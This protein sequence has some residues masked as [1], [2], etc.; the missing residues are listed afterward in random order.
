[1]NGSIQMRLKKSGIDAQGRRRKNV[2]V[3]D[4]YYR[5]KDPKTG[6]NKQKCRRGFPT[7]RD[8]EEYLAKLQVQILNGEYHEESNLTLGEYLHQW[9]ESYPSESGL[10]PN[11]EYS[12]KLHVTKYII[13]RLGQIPL[14]KLTSRQIEKFYGEL[15]KNGRLR[16]TGGLSET[17]ISYINRILNESLKHAVAHHLI[18]MNPIQ[19]IIKKPVRKQHQASYYTASELRNLLELTKGTPLQVPIALAGLAGLRRGEALGLRE[20]DVDFEAGIIHVQNQITVTDNIPSSNPTKTADS[21]RNIAMLPE[22]SDIL[23]K[24]ISV[25]K[26]KRVLLG[27]EYQENRLIVCNDDG[28]MTNPN[29]FTHHFTT[30]IKQHGVKKIRF[31]DLRHTYASLLL[32]SGTD[33][34]TVS[35]LLGHSTIAITADIYT[36]VLEGTKK[37]AAAQLSSL[38]FSSTPPTMIKELKRNYQANEPNVI[39]LLSN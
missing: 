28:T 29:Y 4:V 2:K 9:I 32:E 39:K 24:Q 13:P 11:T 19:E 38:I 21:I 8:A 20:N 16:H 37:K 1:M 18:S 36:H 31:H 5:I 17:T 14:Q 25:N 12:Y 26:Q 27:D 33:I 35:S 3:Y 10:R 15:R 30:F 34:K 6:K 23:K 7:K 22:L